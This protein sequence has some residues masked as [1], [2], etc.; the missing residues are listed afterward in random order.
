[1]PRIHAIVQFLERFAPCALAED[2]DN[3]GLLIGDASRDATVAMT[4]LTLTSDVAQEAVERGAHFIVTH[5]PIL[6]RPVQ[7]ITA[8]TP[9]GRVLMRLLEAGIAVYCPHTAYDS[10]REG[11][12]QQLADL[13]ELTN[14][15]VLRPQL[16]ATRD[17]AAE[18]LPLG[19]GRFGDLPSSM[20]LSEFVELAKQ[21]LGIEYVN[22]VGDSAM[23]IARIGIAC[24]S[25]AEFL[26][27]ARKA[28]CQLLLTGEARFHAS[29]EAVALDT[30][31]VLA[32]HYATE[33]PAVEKL[34]EILSD[35]FSDVDVWASR[36][37]AD[38]LRWG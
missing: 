36:Q 21:R 22:Y 8:D 7:K 9:D 15:D 6:F 4:C 33:R 27:D 5:H 11:I 31:L 12:N 32:G 28:G 25:A 26:P 35:E 2:W 14:I 16:L 24:G 34:A 20:T 30:A 19:S 18:E 13:F 10:A 38:P 1:M 29:L 3:V 23:Q 17:E 37:E